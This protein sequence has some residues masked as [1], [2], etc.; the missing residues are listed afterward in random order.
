MATVFPSLYRARAERIN[1]NGSVSVKVPAVFGETL[2][3]TD[4]FFGDMPSAPGMGWVM[5]QAGNPEFPVWTSGAG[6]GADGGGLDEVWIGPHPPEGDGYELWY[7]PYNHL[8]P[9]TVTTSIHATTSVTDRRRYGERPLSVLHVTT[10]ISTRFSRRDTLT[11][12]VHATTGIVVQAHL[13]ETRTTAVVGSTSIIEAFRP[14]PHPQETPTTTITATTSVTD[15]VR[16]PAPTAIVG[17]YVLPQNL[18]GNDPFLSGPMVYGRT[19]YTVQQAGTAEVWAINLDAPGVNGGAATV[20]RTTLT[21]AYVSGHATTGVATGGFMW[22]LRSGPY[23]IVKINVATGAELGSV[24]VAY[25]GQCLGTAS[26]V[27]NSDGTNFVTRIDPAGPTIAATSPNLAGTVGWLVYDAVNNA[28]WVLS[29]TGT[30]GANDRKLT[31]LDA[32]TLAIVGTPIQLPGSGGKQLVHSVDQAGV[33]IYSVDGGTGTV[34]RVKISD[35]TVTTY[36]SVLNVF[37]ANEG[38][39][40]AVVGNTLYT[41]HKYVASSSEDVLAVIDIPTMVATYLSSYLDPTF[42]GYE[43]FHWDG[44]NLWLLGRNVVSG[45]QSDALIKMG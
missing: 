45:N 18:A 41:W 43:G 15:A 29:W 38:S 7:D 17:Q 4:Q 24:A 20:T 23:R 39:P 9:E 21:G 42:G 25:S 12:A 31:R 28:I 10:E 2:I 34:Y 37:A 16:G 35:M 22:A 26:W 36:P 1:D 13:K 33:Y 32:T 40:S 11:T 6:I 5:F 19:L 14:L 27:Y 30:G 44:T 8:T 3:T